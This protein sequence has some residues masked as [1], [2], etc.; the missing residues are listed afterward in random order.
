MP[1][2]I[3]CVT[4]PVDDLQKSM[5]FYQNVM[6]FSA[7]EQDEDH[8]AFDVD[9]VYLVLLN[10]S[11]FGVYVESVGHRP[12]ARGNSESILSYFT[13]TREEVD[14]LIAK[15]KA[16]GATASDAEDDDGVYSGCFTDPDGHVWEVLHDAA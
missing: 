12:A 9:G 6:G 15:A 2:A 1:V 11:D 8:A 3:S 13:D 16:A 14:A 5:A 4:L 10:R 7:D